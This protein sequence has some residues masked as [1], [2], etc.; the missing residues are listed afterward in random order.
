MRTTAN[1]TVR[2]LSVLPEAATLQN[3]REKTAFMEKVAKTHV[4]IA[5][6]WQ[7]SSLAF[8]II[9]MSTGD[10]YHG[11]LGFLC[12]LIV[13]IG[14][15]LSLLTKTNPSKL[16]SWFLNAIALASLLTAYGLYVLF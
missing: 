5:F 8:G 14:Y 15:F 10:Y 6:A 12:G 9:L 2:G 1:S 4:Y 16:F 7:I 13:G 11:A 3:N